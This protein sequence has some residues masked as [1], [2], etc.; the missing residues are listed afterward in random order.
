MLLVFMAGWQGVRVFAEIE[1]GRFHFSVLLIFIFFA[2]NFKLPVFS[3]S[4][5]RSEARRLIEI[6]ND[7]SVIGALGRIYGI[8]DIQEKTNNPK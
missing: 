3:K 2:I 5:R 6:S 1:A 7:G 4:I 8:A